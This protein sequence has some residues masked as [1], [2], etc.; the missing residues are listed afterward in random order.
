MTDERPARER[1]IETTSRLLELQGYTATGLNQIISESNT[2]KGSLYHYF[3]D[4]KEE[5]TAEAIR[6]KHKMVEQH[7]RRELAAYDDPAE[8][9]EQMLGKMAAKVGEADC[10]QGLHIAAVAIETAGSSD[11]LRQA[12]HDAYAAWQDAFAEK[13]LASGVEEA[14]AAALATTIV[15]AI[16]GA[17]I[18]T[19]TAQD[20][21][22][23]RE[24]A[25][26]LG[27]LIRAVTS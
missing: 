18:M 27:T 10:R 7:V 4:G 21:T 5:L 9:V 6:F 16:E 3:P 20:T 17:I 12:C 25:R 14:E 23:L 26:L 24:V 8:A 11:R 22:P 2:P 15:A 1:L 13:L 19:R